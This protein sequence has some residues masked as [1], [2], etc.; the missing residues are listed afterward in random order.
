MTRP[1]TTTASGHLAGAAAIRHLLAGVPNVPRT[2]ATTVTL[3]V[4]LIATVRGKP[5]GKEMMWNPA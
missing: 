2:V 3:R 5:A 4:N 1:V